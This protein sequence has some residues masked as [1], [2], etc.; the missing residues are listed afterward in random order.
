M[1]VQPS[2]ALTVED[3][4]VSAIPVAGV[5]EGAAGLDVL[6]EVLVDG[7]LDPLGLV[8]SPWGWVESS[9]PQPA[10]PTSRTAA[11]AVP[12]AR[13]RVRVTWSS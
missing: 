7:L 10:V 9:P 5:T 3:A 6:V 1:A 8:G 4:S 12:A 2:G 13:R 11:R